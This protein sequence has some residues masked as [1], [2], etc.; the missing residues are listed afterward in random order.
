M[1]YPEL[2][3]NE[4]ESIPSSW[5]SHSSESHS[6]LFINKTRRKESDNFD[7]FLC[8][9]PST[10]L[11]GTGH[12][13]T[14]K[15]YPPSL[16]IQISGEKLSHQ[17]TIDWYKDGNLL[18]QSSAVLL[19]NQESNLI[20]NCVS[21]QLHV[22]G[23]DEKRRK[24]QVQVEIRSGQ[25]TPIG[26]FHSKPIKVISK[27]SK[28]RQS[29]KNM[30][31]CIHHGTTVALFNRVRAQT[32]STKYLGVSSL[33]SQQKDRGTC[34]VTRTTSWDPFLI[35][36]VDL[37]RS[38][39]TPS[40]VPFS[41]HPTISHY[42]PPPAIA[43][44]NHQGSLALHYNQPIVLQCVSTGLVSPVLIIRRVE[45]GSMVMGGNRLNDLSYPS[46]GEWGDEALGDPV[47]QL[48]KVGFQIVQDPS[49][50]Q[51]NKSTFQEQDKFFLPPVTHWTLPQASPTINYLACIN[52]VVGM[53]RVTD[54]RKIVSRFTTEIEDIK[55]AVRKRRLSYQQ[56][57]T[58]V[59]SSNR[60]R[61]NSLNDELLSRHVGGDAGRCPDQPLNGDCWTE[62]VSDSAVWTIVGTNSTSFAFWTPPDYSKP[63]YDLQD[64]P[65]VESIQSL[66]STVLSLVGEHFTSDLTVWFGDVPSI[67][68]EFKSNQ[69]LS[70]T[71]PERHELLDSFSTQLDLDT[72]RHKIPL[73]LVQEDG[74]IY[75]SLLFYSF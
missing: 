72:N 37:S 24:A 6:T 53:H 7:E 5:S 34:F 74:I 8:P 42:P 64:F 22:S 29:V 68:T 2:L 57:S 47:S 26:T 1:N 23:A 49:I 62:D 40:P 35:Y 48:H 60:R 32:I 58:T 63:F 14:A 12:W 4:V 67:Q 61:V 10:I 38:P 30:D 45:K 50:A 36:I 31:L 19:A 44:Q 39:N 28:K 13:W 9:P 11:S 73:L 66:S 59:K 55:M 25:G 65:Y 21:K 17:G 71:V 15:Q 52:D 69:L 3:T 46:G 70:C 54:E 18:D 75:N 56:H 27:P 51:Y 16:T 43:I 20:G 41:H 33:D